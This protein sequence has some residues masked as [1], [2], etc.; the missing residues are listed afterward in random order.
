MNKWTKDD[1]K[2]MK[3]ALELAAKATDK[4]YP[5]PMVGAVIVKGGRVVGKGYHKKAGCDHAEIV[6]IKNARDN[7]KGAKMYVS[8]EPCYNHGKTPPCTDAIMKSGIKEVIVAAKDPNPITALGGVK[9]L[10]K[11]GITVKT[12]ILEHEAQELNR[13]FNKY[14]TRKMPY[15]TIKLAQSLDGKI[16]ARDGSSKWISSEPSRRYVKEIRKDFDAI[17]VGANTLRKDD[18][19]LLD[20]DKKGYDV[21]RV[22]ADTGLN[23]SDTSNLIKT[24]SKAPVLIITTELASK[25]KID[26][27]RKIK[28]VDVAVVKSKRGKVS[29]NSLLKEL[30]GRDVVNVLVEGGGELIG[31]LVDEGFVDEAI[32]FI[33]P[34]LIGGNFS[35]VKGKGVRNIKNA[36]E[37]EEWELSSVGDDILI[38]GKITSKEK[39]K[40]KKE[41]E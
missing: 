3:M 26:R 20:W 22:V 32:F 14:I 38:R 16:A 9:K 39:G 21:L 7:A 11:S 13:K 6:A 28:G 36:I 41:K 15:V 25:K 18:P 10:R 27:L 24:A 19:F 37:F 8:L 29:L 5:N 12:G 34:K 31:G 30:A 40:R 2:Y 1:I 17:V 33:S 23:I 4:T 35:S